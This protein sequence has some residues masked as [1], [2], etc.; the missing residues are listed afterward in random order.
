LPE[1][2]AKRPRFEMRLPGP[3]ARRLLEHARRLLDAHGC[4]DEPLTWSPRGD[5]L[6]VDELP[7]PDPDALDPDRVHDALARQRTPSQAAE[8]LVVT[9]EHLR[10]VVR[11]HPPESGP[12]ASTAPPRVRLAALL[13]PEELRV[14]VKQG[15]SLRRIAARYDISRKTI[16]D[17]L[18]AHGIPIPPKR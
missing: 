11:Q 4:H 1:F 13:T 10:Y 7:G 2:L 6:S 12:P 9:L 16:H 18:I 3:T 14:L 17:E 15:T 8:E 5:A